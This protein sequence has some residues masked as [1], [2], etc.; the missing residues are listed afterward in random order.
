[1]VCP[2]C[3]VVIG[4]VAAGSATIFPALPWVATFGMGGASLAYITGMSVLSLTPWGGSLV[5]TGAA[6]ALYG[7]VHESKYLSPENSMLNSN[8]RTFASKKAG[9]EMHRCIEGKKKSSILQSD[10]VFERHFYGKWGANLFKGDN[11]HIDNFYFSLCTTTNVPSSNE[12]SLYN[13]VWGVNIRGIYDYLTT[14]Y[15]LVPT[16]QDF[17]DAQDKIRIFCSKRSVFL[18]QI[19]VSYNKDINATV[20]KIDVP[21]WREGKVPYFD[22]D[23]TFLYNTIFGPLFYEELAV[24]VEGEHQCMMGDNPSCLELDIKFSEICE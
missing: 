17:D 18:D 15:K 9:Y 1:M 11:D 24:L 20:I 16:V 4:G 6:Y 5:L 8:I 12:S 14:A 7:Y 10:S 22:V 19:H 13:L 23:F 3:P 2:A 21:Y